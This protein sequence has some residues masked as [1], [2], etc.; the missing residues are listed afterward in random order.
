MDMVET[1]SLYALSLKFLNFHLLLSTCSMSHIIHVTYRT[2]NSKGDYWLDGVHIQLPSS[3]VFF[4][5]N[6]EFII[7]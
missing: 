6:A 4:S 3:K 1:L 2:D 7:S 5:N